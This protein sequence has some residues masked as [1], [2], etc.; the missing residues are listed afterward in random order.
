MSF[1]KNGVVFP[2]KREANWKKHSNPAEPMLTAGTCRSSRPEHIPHEQPELPQRR[3]M[4][5]PV[6]L[7]HTDDLSAE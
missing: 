5:Q 3:L 2:D 6:C 1:N 7:L 4:L